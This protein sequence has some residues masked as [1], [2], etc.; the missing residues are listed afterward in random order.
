MPTSP[1]KQ[2]AAQLTEQVITLRGSTDIVTEFFYF[3]INSILFQRGIY[4]ADTFCKV[5]K[6]GLTVLIS[7]DEGLKSYLENINRQVAGWL[8][9][10]Q[11]QKLVVVISGVESG[12]SLERWVFQVH[13]ERPVEPL[14]DGDRNAPTP[15]STKSR[16][17][18]ANEIQAIIR[19]ITASVT[20]LPMFNE[21]C[22]FDLLV[23]TNNDAQ[24]PV[25][26]AESDPKYI[27]DSNEVRL[28]S[29]T[30]QIHKVDTM[31]A[32]KSYKDEI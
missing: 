3:S 1:M 22:A 12:E 20:F 2:Q 9:K 29:F 6:Y 11:V 17:E 26:W 24:V 19:Q 16:K 10:G 25:E 4:P 28:R 32:F 30:T 5:Q 14:R 27:Q 7:Q 13:H 8:M 18:V 21:T 15:P 23:Y 31:V